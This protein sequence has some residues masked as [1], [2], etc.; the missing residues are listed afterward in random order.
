MKQISIFMIG[1][2]LISLSLFVGEAAAQKYQGGS[3]DGH[4]NGNTGILKLDGTPSA[5]V[6]SDS[7]YFGGSFDGQSLFATGVIT[8]EGAASAYTFT[9]G[10]YFGGSY[11]GSG[12]NLGAGSGWIVINIVP[13]TTFYGIAGTGVS[14][15]LATGDAGKIYASTDSGNTWTEQPQAASTESLRSL[16]LSDNFAP[17]LA[18]KGNSTFSTQGFGSAVAVGVGGTIL[19]SADGGANWSSVNNSGNTNALNAIDGVP[20]AVAKG[21]AV[22][23]TLGSEGFGSAVA[24]GVGGTILRSADGVSWQSISPVTSNELRGVALSN[25]FVATALAKNNGT[26]GT[27]GFGSAVAVGVGGTILRSNTGGDSWSA[28]GSPTTNTLN[29][30]AWFGSSSAVAVKESQPVKSRTAEFSGGLSDRSSENAMQKTLSPQ[31]VQGF[32]S[33]VAVGVGGTI[34]RSTNGGANWSVINAGITRDLT[35][36]V[37]LDELNGYVSG[38]QATIAKTTNGGQE[39]INISPDT[40][41]LLNAIVVL[42]NG[43]GVSVGT[44]GNAYTTS[45]GGTKPLS[46]DDKT[47]GFPKPPVAFALKQ[48]YPNPFNPATVISYELLLVSEVSLKVYDILGREVATLASAR[49][50]AGRYAVNF[51]AQKLASGI[52]FYRLVAASASDKFVQTKKMVLVK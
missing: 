42:P 51:N 15:F 33:A 27:N 26:L 8:L 9:A 23:G 25:D 18:A 37:M 13:A 12:S 34:L 20:G 36:V 38:A 50:A 10:K 47:D 43:S 49:Q 48:N 44:N 24:V 30:V 5:Y 17:S 2:C 41:D 32:G 22:S 7:K 11:D 14:T 3:F 52:Y 28:V 40:P 1:L 4:A 21:N 46:A 16:I 6:F 35:S 19:R 29:S 45:S 31:G 39:W